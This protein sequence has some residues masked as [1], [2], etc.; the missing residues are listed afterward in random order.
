MVYE[1]QSKPSCNVS[2][3]KHCIFQENQRKHHATFVMKPNRRCIVFVNQS[4]P[5]CKMHHGIQETLHGLL[6][7]R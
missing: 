1:N 3:K 6:E 7:T 4:E 5:S 2:C